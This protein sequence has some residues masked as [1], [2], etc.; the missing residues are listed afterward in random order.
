MG[1]QVAAEAVEEFRD[2][3]FFV[4]LASVT[5]PQLVPSAIVTALG[6]TQVAG[7]PLDHLRQYLADKETLLVLDN[8][9]QVIDAAPHLA[10][11]LRGAPRMKLL[12]TTRAALHISGEQEFAVPPLELPDASSQVPHE[13][14]ATNEAVVLFVERASA[15]RPG[16]RVTPENARSLVE[17]TSR[18]DGLPLAIELAAARIKLL[19]PQDISQRLNDRLGLLAGG[20]RDLPRRQQTLRDAIAWSYDLLD[21]P[22]RRL[23]ARLAAFRGGAA[24]E[25]VEAVCGPSQELGMDVLEALGVL[26]D[27]SLLMQREAGGTSRL[28]MLETIREFAWE[29]LATSGGAAE[30]AERHARAYLALADEAAGHL[31]SWQQ[32]VW[33]DRLEEEHDNLRAALTWAVEERQTDVALRLRTLLWRFWQIRGHLEEASQRLAEVLAL[34][35]GGARERAQAL[36]AAGSVAYWQGAMERAGDLYRAHLRAMEELDDR[37]G[38]ANAL[39]NLSSVFTGGD[40]EQA[41]RSAQESLSIA[42]ELGDEDGIVKGL[43]GAGSVAWMAEDWDGA[44]SNFQEALEFLR[45]LDD[46]FHLGWTLF[47]LGTA[48][49]RAGRSDRSRPLLEEGLRIFHRLGDITGVLFHLHGFTALALE[50]GQ[51]ERAVRLLGATA[52][53]RETSGAALVDKV[54]HEIPGLQGALVSLGDERVRAL[55]AEGAAMHPEQLVSYTLA[56]SRPGDPVEVPPDGVHFSIR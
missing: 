31:L 50:D 26:V 7:S 47:M 23:L 41:A 49:I 27:Q 21:G 56:D 11:V 22:P 48:E 36:E 40:P 45:R 12:V 54:S 3:V 2:G 16:F 46:P 14:L 30:I 35:G 5:D 17:I 52:R 33:L 25:Q 28:L 24:L 43:F 55:M 53:L 18:L 38:V 37:A 6:L 8:F 32:V 15:V 34:P 19:S 13:E 10:E 42:R 4:P 39:Y 29:Q 51:P 44:R 9:E 20:A 1:L